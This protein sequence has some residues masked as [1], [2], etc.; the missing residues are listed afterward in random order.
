MAQRS[1]EKRI[2]QA[3]KSTGSSPH[4]LNL[5]QACQHQI[6]ISQYPFSIGFIGL[7]LF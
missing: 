1:M 6:D 4:G 5:L 7:T 3:R 2:N